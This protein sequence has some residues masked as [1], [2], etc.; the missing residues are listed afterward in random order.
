MS[1]AFT[2]E[3]IIGHLLELS[4]PSLAAQ[5]SGPSERCFWVC[6]RYYCCHHHPTGKYCE[7]QVV[8]CF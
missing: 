8:V 7:P 5:S 4:S 2:V 6:G 3:F 1:V